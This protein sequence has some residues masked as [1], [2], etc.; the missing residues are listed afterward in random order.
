MNCRSDA[1]E[2]SDDEVRWVRRD[3]AWLSLDCTRL[4]YPCIWLRLRC[5]AGNRGTGRNE[6]A[7]GCRR[8]R[9]GFAWVVLL[10]RE[11]AALLELSSRLP[12]SRGRGGGRRTACSELGRGR[13]SFSSASQRACRDGIRLEWACSDCTSTAELDGRRLPRLALLRPFASFSRE[14]G[15]EGHLVLRRSVVFH[16]RRRV[17]FRRADHSTS[18]K[19]SQGSKRRRSA[20]TARLSLRPHTPAR[21]ALV[22]LSQDEQTRTPTRPA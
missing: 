9:S 3:A 18:D 10:L 22:Q 2:E 14:D 17:H 11:I 16:P 19:S 8:C 20:R 5:E 4:R 13:G 6:E 1:G 7:E 15:D 12:A 21:P